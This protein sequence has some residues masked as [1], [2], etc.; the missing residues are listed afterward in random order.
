MYRFCGKTWSADDLTLIRTLI[1][2]RPDA[3]RT[4]LS[5][6]VCEAFDWRSPNGK[7]KEMSCRVAMLKMLRGGLIDMPAPSRR[8]SFYKLVETPESDPQPDTIISI[9]ALTDLAVVPVAPRG[10][11]SRLWNEFVGRHH[12]L[13]YKMLPGAQIRYLIMDG[14]R[15]LGAMG[16]GASRKRR[17]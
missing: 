5:R 3:K 11:M 4:V 15:V 12:Y 8:P 16:F 17:S 13:G 7:L 14:D 1:A 6:V 9:H 10:P 2:E